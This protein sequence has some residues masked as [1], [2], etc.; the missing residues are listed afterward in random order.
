MIH[1]MIFFLTFI[2]IGLVMPLNKYNFNLDQNGY[3]YI[4]A[5]GSLMNQDSRE[6]D[7]GLFLPG[8]PVFV[9]SR[10]GYKRIFDGSKLVISVNTYRNT[11]FSAVIYKF[12]ISLLPILDFRERNYKRALLNNKYVY[13]PSNYCLDKSLPIYIYIPNHNLTRVHRVLKSNLNFDYLNLVIQGIQ[14]FGTKFVKLFF[15]TT[16]NLPKVKF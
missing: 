15:Q 2:F 9:S 14:E 4:C 8:L 11:P 13:T 10:F 16:Y 6:S 3:C 1:F 5:Y 7:V 12:P